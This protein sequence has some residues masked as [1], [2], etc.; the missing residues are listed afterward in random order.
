MADFT[1]A[2][3]SAAVSSDT[4]PSTS[5]RRRRWQ[6]TNIV[7]VVRARVLTGLGCATGFSGSRSA[8]STRSG[9][10]RVS[11]SHMRNSSL[12]DRQIAE[13]GFRSHFDYVG[14]RSCVNTLAFS[15]NHHALS[16]SSLPSASSS[17]SSLPAPS[18]SS[19]SS[20]SIPP[21][22]PAEAR[23]WSDYLMLSGGDDCDL[24]L[25]PITGQPQPMYA[26]AVPL[27]LAS[28]SSSSFFRL[29][30]LCGLVALT[31]PHSHSLTLKCAPTH[32]LSLPLTH[33]L[34]LIHSLPLTHSLVLI[35]SLP[36]SSL[37]CT[38]MGMCIVWSG[39]VRTS[40][41]RGSARATRT[42]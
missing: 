9:L 29:V 39:T 21:T 34:V 37:L 31:H 10:R 7:N 22:P 14:H 32:P 17:P 11:G 25:W 27:P 5:R 36:H 3:S 20:S 30:C 4:V 19:S 12:V 8:T 26:V 24:L 13:H 41:R 2:T 38:A 23:A 6:H 42:W 18:P 40:S 1:P 28:T 16:A 33:S 35:H 15:H